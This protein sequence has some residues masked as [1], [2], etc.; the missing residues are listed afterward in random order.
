[1]S[2]TFSSKE[3]KGL[4]AV[5]FFAD[6]FLRADGHLAEVVIGAVVDIEVDIALDA[7]QTAYIGVLPELPGA[8]V[9]ER[10]DVVMGYPVGILIEDG[11]VEIAGLKFKIGIDNGLDSI[12][13]LHDVEPLDDGRTKL[14][15]GLILG[16]ML[17]IEHWGQV[18]ILEF[19]G[20]DEVPG[21]LLGWAVD[22][23][24]MV[25]TTGE[26]VLTG[27]IEVIAEV[28]V[29]LGG[30][31]GGLDHDEADGALVD[32]AIVLEFV[33][34]DAALMVGDVDAVDLVAFGIAH[35]AI[36][37]APAEAEGADEEIIEEPDVA[38]DNGCA[39]D[40]PA[41][42]GQTSQHTHNDIGL[43]TASRAMVSMGSTNSLPANNA[44]FCHK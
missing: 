2:A 37:G 38:G 20:I 42:A 43:T 14:L 13:M 12:V 8:L 17:Y 25:S 22:A 35:V 39:T 1:M 15:V 6:G 16:L 5:G 34:V 40:P 24:E 36:E 7:G 21:L 29:G 3:G 26:A 10:I 23:I 19:H 18:A 33:P 28:L 30:S 32:G 27:L 4:F 41:P 31:L 44:T 11:I 9:F